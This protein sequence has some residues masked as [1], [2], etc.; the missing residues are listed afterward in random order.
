MLTQEKDEGS[1]CAKEDEDRAA[2]DFELEE[3]NTEADEEAQPEGSPQ[4]LIKRP[5]TWFLKWVCVEAL[6][7][8]ADRAKREDNEKEPACV[9]KRRDRLHAE[10]IS[11]KRSEEMGSPK[12]EDE[13][14]SIDDLIELTINFL[15]SAAH[16]GEKMGGAVTAPSLPSCLFKKQLILLCPV[17]WWG[18]FTAPGR[19][20][21][22]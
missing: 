7:L 8:K 19:W 9:V 12:S 13:Q 16:A 3:N 15:F 14:G 20:R 10:P 5:V 2:G 1:Q 11:A 4:H 6:S 22:P 17:Q 21:R 18:R